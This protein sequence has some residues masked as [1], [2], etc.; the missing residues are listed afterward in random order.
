MNEWSPQNL[1]NVLICEKLDCVSFLYNFVFKITGYLPVTHC[2]GPWH[3]ISPT[4]VTEVYLN[5]LINLP[6]FSFHYFGIT[7]FFKLNFPLRE[8]LKPPRIPKKVIIL[9]RINLNFFFVI[10]WEKTKLQSMITMMSTWC[11]CNIIT[12]LLHLSWEV[13][14]L[15][16]PSIYCQFCTIFLSLRNWKE[17][18]VLQCSCW[19]CESRYDLYLYKDWGSICFLKQKQTVWN[20]TKLFL[21]WL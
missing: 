12:I 15:K 17:K 10:Y 5:S 19:R 2:F 14:S 7:F 8:G 20:R 3:H 21:I 1:A 9:L 18:Y 16:F 11:Q 4:I 6:I 13:S